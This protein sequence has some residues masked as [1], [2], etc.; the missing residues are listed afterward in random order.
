[1]TE[2]DKQ[3]ENLKTETKPRVP[4]P[5]FSAEEWDR[6]IAEAEH[7]IK[8]LRKQKLVSKRD[9]ETRKKIIAG[10]GLFK[11]IKSDPDL[12]AMVIP[13]IQAELNESDFAYAFES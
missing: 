1:M 12:R 10:A 9:H 7:R 6:K 2:I 8:A 4:K 11:A 5:N 3:Q 13:A